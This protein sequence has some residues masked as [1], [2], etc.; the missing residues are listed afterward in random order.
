MD[1]EV[2]LDYD[3]VLNPEYDA[4]T[5][6]WGCG[7]RMPTME[8]FNELVNNCTWVW[9]STHKGYLIIASNGNSIFLPAAGYRSDDTINNLESEGNYWIGTY[10]RNWLTNIFFGFNSSSHDVLTEN[11]SYQMCNIG[12]SVRPVAVPKN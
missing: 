10:N 7:Y 8:E 12:M 3:N 6:N 4:A 9:D 1:L 5:V 2:N 11:S